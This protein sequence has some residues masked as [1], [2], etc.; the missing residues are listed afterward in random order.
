M[1]C[2]A[3]RSRWRYRTRSARPRTLYARSVAT[4]AQIKKEGDISDSFGSLSGKKFTPLEPRFA[5][6]KARLIEG[7]EDAVIASW[8]RLLA[9]LREEVPLI[10][11]LGSKVIPEIDFKD[12]DVASQHF[13]D[14]H[15]KRGVAIIRNVVPQQ[16]ALDL[17]Q[18]LREYIAANPHTKAFP[19]DN[20][21]VFELYWYVTATPHE[22]TQGAR[23]HRG[24]E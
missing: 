17:K 24:T 19:Q 12:L 7:R 16:E 5:A 8:Q 23:G 3:R 18:E 1:Q 9:R 20:P 6:Q 22:L 21:Q 13:K 2:F 15:R 10:A 11:S 14:E 4:A